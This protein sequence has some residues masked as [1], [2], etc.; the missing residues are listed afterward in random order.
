MLCLGS[1][2]QML[3]TSTALPGKRDSTKVIC[4]Y[5]AT[6]IHFSIQGL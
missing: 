4:K 5:V 6:E 1:D 3:V 2:P